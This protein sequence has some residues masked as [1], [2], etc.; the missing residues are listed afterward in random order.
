MK[1]FIT[2]GLSL[3][4]LSVAASAQQASGENFRRGGTAHKFSHNE[5]TRPEMLQLQKDHFQYKRA[6]HHAQRDG[7]VGPLE[8]RRLH[9]IRKHNRHDL[10]HFRHNRAH[11]HNRVI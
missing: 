9:K 5:I 8:R 7:R 3:I 6:Q 11:R 1:K 4:I 2:L 10:Y